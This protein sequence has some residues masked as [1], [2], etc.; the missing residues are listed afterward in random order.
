[1]RVISVSLNQALRYWGPNVVICHHARKQYNWFEMLTSEMWTRHPDLPIL[2]KHT[3]KSTE[4]HAEISQRTMGFQDLTCLNRFSKT[5]EHLIVSQSLLLFPSTHM[6]CWCTM[7]SVFHRDVSD[8]FKPGWSC[9][10]SL[11]NQLK[12]NNIMVL[13]WIA[14]K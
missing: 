9:E 1:M 3:H 4:V 11:N 8:L 12:E 6:Q 2:L 14:L 7:R 10:L 13:F 5:N